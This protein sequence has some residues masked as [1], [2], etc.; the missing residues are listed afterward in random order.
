MGHLVSFLVVANFGARVPE[1]LEAVYVLVVA[2]QKEDAFE[3]LFRH[4]EQA[5]A[6]G[7]QLKEF[8]KRKVKARKVRV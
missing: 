1:V 8:E 4:A 6:K 2:A 3:V 7:D 5:E